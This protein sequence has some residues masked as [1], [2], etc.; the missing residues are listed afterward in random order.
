MTT[1]TDTAPDLRDAILAALTTTPA[2][3]HANDVERP[4]AVHGTEHRYNATCALCCGEADTLTDAVITALGLRTEW[5]V[6][7]G[8]FLVTTASDNQNNLRSRALAELRL[9]ELAA[10]GMQ[11]LTVV[12]R[13]VSDWQRDA[14]PDAA[15]PSVA[16]EKEPTP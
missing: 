8:P 14:E 4:C 16:A 7:S 1:D 11:D 12:H 2:R 15:P 5:A 13:T 6:M 9:A 10:G 3:R